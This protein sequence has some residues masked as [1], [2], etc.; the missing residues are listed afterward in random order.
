MGLLK[1]APTIGALS[2]LGG[3][4]QGPSAGTVTPQECCS[5]RRK[6]FLLSRNCGNWQLL[7]EQG[8]L[9]TKPSWCPQSG[10]FGATFLGQHRSLTSF[11]TPG[12]PNPAGWGCSRGVVTV[13]PLREGHNPSPVISLGMVLHTHPSQ[14]PLFCFPW[15]KQDKKTKKPHLPT[16]QWGTFAWHSAVCGSNPTK[17][18]AL[19]TSPK[20]PLPHSPTLPTPF[21]GT[22]VPQIPQRV[23]SP[24]HPCQTSS[25]SSSPAQ[26]GAGIRH[27]TVVEL[28][29]RHL[30]R[31]G[32]KKQERSQE[33]LP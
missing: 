5:V 17:Q 33:A 23:L 28:G 30:Q 24:S 26:A 21:D 1:I 22:R 29:W 20:Q 11:P 15:F 3:T 2:G 14:R 32:V 19:A 13:A 4:E 12:T 9:S 18:S 27:C 16:P 31:A 6:I 25:H 10:G 7:P 8:F